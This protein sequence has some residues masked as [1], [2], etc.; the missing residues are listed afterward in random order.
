MSRA[1]TKFVSWNVRGLNHPVKR[2]K[3]F[4]HLAKL[5]AEVIF[6]QE[7]HLRTSDIPRLQRGCISQVFHSKFNSKCRGTAILIG[8]NVQF[9]S[10]KVVADING[11]YV[12]V[13]GKLYNLPVVLVNIY[14]PN[15]DNP[16]FFKELFE[17]IPDPG[18]HHLILGG[19]FN[20]VLQPP[21]DR[22]KIPAGPPSKSAHVIEAF[23]QFSGV[24]DVWRFKN[25]TLREFSFFSAAHQTFSRLDFFL[26]DKQMLPLVKL[27][28][29]GSIVISD[30]A[31]V[32]ME[33]WLQNR[34]TSRRNWRLNP[35]LLAEKDFVDLISA[36]IDF[37][38][39]TNQLPDTN[40]FTLWET[41]K[42]YLR[43]H[44]I[45]YTARQ[46]KNRSKRFTELTTLIHDIDQQYA[47]SPSADLR[48]KRIALQTEFDILASKQAEEKFLKSRQSHYEHGERASRL[49]SHQLRQFSSANYITEIQSADGSIKSDPKDINDEFKHFYSSLY[50]SESCHA[51]NF[52]ENLDLPT[53]SDD[54]MSSLEEPI[55]AIEIGQ[56]I[57][58]MKNRKAPGPDGYPIEFYKAFANKLTPLLRLVYTESLM[59]K[60]LPVSMTQATISVLPKKG[61]DPRKCESYRPISLL[62]CDYK[63]LTKILALRLE[64]VLPTVVHPDQT[65][66]VKGRQLYHNLRRLFN[67]VYSEHSSQLPEVVI[68]LDAHKAFDR[69]EYGHLFR[70][71]SRFGFGPTFTSWIHTLYSKPQAAVRTNDIHSEYFVLHRGT[72]QGC[73]LSPLLFNL[74]IEPLAVALR[75]SNEILG[76]NRGG[77]THKVSLYADDLLLFLSDPENSIPKCLDIIAQF[78]LAS[79]Y[80]INFSKS[81]LFPINSKALT[82]SFDT[83]EFKVATGPLTYL[84]VKVT[85][86]YKDLFK[87]NFKPLLD[88][89]SKDTS[90]WST[91]PLSL[92]GRINSVKMVIL[93]KFLFLFQTV[94]IFLPKSYF[95]ELDKCISTFIWNKTVPRVRK[96]VL[97]K[98]KINGGLALPNFLYYYWAAN[99]HK[100]IVWYN[101][102]LEGEGPNW[103]RME[104]QACSPVS[105]VSVLCGPLPI[106]VCTHTENPIVRGTLRIWTQLRKHFGITQALVSMP[107]TANPLFKPS[108]LDTVFQTWFGKGLH[109]VGDLFINGTFG[110]F[111]QLMRKHNLVKSHF[112]RYLQIR[113]FTRTQFPSFPHKPS[114]G[115]LDECL[116]LEPHITGCVSKLYSIIQDMEGN[117]HQLLKER[118]GEDLNAEL[119]EETW[120]SV[121]KRI[122]KS[123][124]CIRHGL[125][126][127]KIVHRVHLC[128]F[129][130]AQIYP[131]TDPTCIRCYQ[132][133]ATL[134]HM[135]WAC[136]KLHTFWSEIFNTFSYVCKK[137]IDPDPVISVFGVAPSDS[138]LTRHQSDLI[139]FSTLLARR[140]IL[141]NWRCA[142]P[143]SHSRWVREVM[144]FVKLEKIRCTIQGHSGYSSLNRFQKTWN[145]FL[146]Y[147]ADKFDANTLDQ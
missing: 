120:Q 19:D 6:L 40:I 21:L 114:A 9:V 17:C 142:A 29:Y 125:I 102:F 5:K 49:L 97:E 25:P 71:L 134:G 54:D 88:Q 16:N 75:Q 10:S 140:L 59:Q 14:A 91:L 141:F 124:I 89:A 105:L 90:R 1:S 57:K 80:K 13:Q 77:Q 46:N 18:T 4:S 45:E 76:I 50:S 20:T 135:F 43:G 12:I 23:C 39:E 132:A 35:T 112:F 118:W 63:I 55:S 103:S 64:S 56:A 84:G 7:T 94:P 27:C 53:L 31:P 139:A 51:N 104:Q 116:K 26:V 15:W 22:S 52:V 72:R 61:K 106:A 122:H 133:P 82:M 66:F 109:C 101:T 41:L 147:F 48:K 36:Q 87:F 47:A 108:L 107:F 121:I 92:A 111:E 93:P 68:S 11:R 70:T 3:V 58:L 79:G 28:S 74:A 24:V 126:Q 38:L 34:L 110:S 119:S 67:I 73:P 95:K 33:L 86:S 85:R 144:A 99:I 8:K 130:L 143:P 113:N 145:A 138:G 96:S 78:S 2:S 42:V 127:F 117:S 137:K 81:E 131:G 62:T 100:V 32:I 44:I 37:F 129:R 69:I 128:G 30:H 115:P 146:G 65:G 98:R 136:P 123:S 83:C 60:K